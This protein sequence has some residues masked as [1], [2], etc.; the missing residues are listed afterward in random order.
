MKQAKLSAM[1]KYA[2]KKLF[3]RK[4]KPLKKHAGETMK[5]IAQ[6]LRRLH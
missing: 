2:R 5:D 3:Q 1:L 4:Y 6:P